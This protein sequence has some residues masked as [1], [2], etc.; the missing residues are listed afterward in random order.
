LKG[1][2]LWAIVSNGAPSPDSAMAA[3]DVQ[4]SDPPPLDFL[5]FDPLNKII[6]FPLKNEPKS[7]NTSVRSFVVAVMLLDFHR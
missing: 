7:T 1:E 3:V 4:T 5:F 2:T 6:L